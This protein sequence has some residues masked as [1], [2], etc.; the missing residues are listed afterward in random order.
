MTT[1][2]KRERA[3]LFLK[4]AL[5]LSPLVTGLLFFGSLRLLKGILLE[6]I[7]GGNLPLLS[8]EAAGAI[9]PELLGLVIAFLGIL[10]VMLLLL[11][12]IATLL[13]SLAGYFVWRD[14]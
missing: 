1:V 7:D 9:A 10:M 12:W 2:G 8:G 5:F 6:K 11:F 13:L 3:S 4:I 14:G